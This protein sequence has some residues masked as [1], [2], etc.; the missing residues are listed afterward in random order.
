MSSGAYNGNLETL[1]LDPVAF[2]PNGRARFEL[3][4]SK[5]AYM[6]NMRLLNIGCVAS[7]KHDYVP[8]LGA[9]TLIKNI[10]LLDQGQV[11]STLRN[12]GPYL[13]FKNCNR[14]NSTNKSSDAYLKR[15]SL[16]YEVKATDNKL[17]HIYSSGS[18]DVG[19]VG[20]A[21]G[22][23][24]AYLDLREVFPILNEM[25]VLPT[26]VFPNLVIEIEFDA[27]INNQLLSDTAAT[28][29]ILRPILC[30]DATGN[31]ALVKAAEQALASQPVLWNEIEND[32]FI[33]PAQDNSAEADNA[34]TLVQSTNNQS[35]GFKGKYI[36]R[37]L[38]T[39]Q[40]T[41]KAAFLTGANAV[42]GFGQKASSVALLNQQLQYKLNGKNVM[43]GFNGVVGPNEAL[44]IVCD[45]YGTIGTF[46]GANLYKWS[47]GAA[48]FSN[49]GRLGQQSFDCVRIGARIADLQIGLT[50]TTNK[51]TAKDGYTNL[52]LAVNLYGEVKKVWT[53]SNGRYRIAYV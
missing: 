31:Q 14:S 28:I 17:D 8:G 52:Q 41:D 45:E 47:N 33:V 43:P 19:Q 35:L 24:V 7:A 34:F 4:A 40:V 15:N 32:V 48:S 3:D 27:N 42:D 20:Q 53:M 5:M 9:L 25:P 50:R 49:F 13:F 1:Y 44:A 23:D 21:N 12:V 39:K 30:V 2:V 29:E 51:D 22:T 6:P 36:E 26:S 16:G 10:R 38:L 37:L 18:A 46:P 11:L